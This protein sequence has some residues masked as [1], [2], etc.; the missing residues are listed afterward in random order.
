MTY[1][2]GVI[3]L[4][5]L[6]SEA[7]NAAL[8]SRS[9]SHNGFEIRYPG[10]KRLG[11][12]AL[13]H[14]GGCPT[15]EDIVRW[16]YAKTT[17]ENFEDLVRALEDLHANGDSATTTF[18]SERLKTFLFLIT[19]QEESNYPPPANGR[20]L[21]YWRF[22]EAA[23]AKLGFTGIEEVVLRTNN[24]QKGVPPLYEATKHYKPA[25]YK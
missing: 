11:D 4:K 12:Y 3:L 24:H 21:T 20:N 14:E 7:P 22:Y 15:H 23:L 9:Y 10:R 8:H 13:I 16:I 5:K 17:E 18:F 25:F 6:H 2:E 19:L 1:E